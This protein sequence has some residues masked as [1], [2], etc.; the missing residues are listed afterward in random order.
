MKITAE[1]KGI[2][3][4]KIDKVYSKKKKELE[5]KLNKKYK[6]KMD[7]ISKKNTEYLKMQRDLDNAYNDLDRE[8]KTDGCHLMRNYKGGYSLCI[9]RVGFNVNDTYNDFMD[10]L[11][12]SEDGDGLLKDILERIS[13]L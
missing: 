5:E 6:V 9:E 1:I 8:M 3:R 10:E 12:L 2:V 4:R 7:K 11:I 13:K